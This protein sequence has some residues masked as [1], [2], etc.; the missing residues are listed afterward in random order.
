MKP[1]YKRPLIIFDDQNKRGNNL[2][3]ANIAKQ[4]LLLRGLMISGSLESAAKYAGIQRAVDTF[5]TLDRISIRREYHEALS[6]EGIDLRYIVKGIKDRA[7]NSPNESVRLNALKTL[8]ASLG[9]DRYEVA[10]EGNKSWEDRL[11]QMNVESNPKSLPFD[12]NNGYEVNVPQIPESVKQSRKQEEDL[13][14][15]L[16]D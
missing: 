14:R 2:G 5:R 1:I 3:K 12:T 11:L 10:E 4:N 15:E 13:G 8:L 16:Y 9:L 7:D 6:A